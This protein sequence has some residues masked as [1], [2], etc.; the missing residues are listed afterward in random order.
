MKKIPKTLLCL[1]SIL[2]LFNSCDT[3]KIAS[4]HIDAKMANADLRYYELKTSDYTFTYWDNNNKKPVLILLHGFGATTEFQWYKQV[5][6]LSKDFRIVMPNLLYFGSSDAT[7]KGYTIADQVQFVNR[8]TDT[9]NIRYFSVCGISYGALVAAEYVDM[10]PDKVNK[11]I[12]TDGPVKFFSDRDA[13]E[14]YK[15]FDV[16]NISDLLLPDNPKEFKKLLD[17]AYYKP[18]YVP[19]FVLNNLYTNLYSYDKNNQTQLLKHLD[20]EKESYNL[21]EYKNLNLPILLIWGNN[22]NLIPKH[23]GE[24][25]NTYFGEKSRLVLLNK[26][27]HLPNF[28]KPGA[29]TKIITDF[30]LE[31]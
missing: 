24:A 7:Q 28:E 14:I 27:A 2:L 18:P 25:L 11:L 22:D 21:K 9:L 17:I 10:Y 5:K 6:K 23:V 30:L 12:I 19:D 3:Y 29:Y 8:L 26:T 1:F 31:D 16:V 15:N 20:D 13:D 4:K